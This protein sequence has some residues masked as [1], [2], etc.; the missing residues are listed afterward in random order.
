VVS[1][2]ES[3]FDASAVP[4]I[5]GGPL[6]NADL[7]ARAEAMALSQRI[8]GS[9][10][11]LLLDAVESFYLAK[12]FN[13]TVLAFDGFTNAVAS[14]ALEAVGA[15]LM[16]LAVITIAT[17]NDAGQDGR[18]S[19]LPHTLDRLHR[20]LDGV[21]DRDV[22]TEKAGVQD[23]KASVNADVVESLKYLRHLRNKWAGHA[24]LDRSIDS[25]ADADRAVS[26]PLIEDALVRL[27]NAHQRL[28]DM[29]T[30][31]DVLTQLTSEPTRELSAD[32]PVTVPMDVD[33][34]AVV[35]HALLVR[36]WAGRAAAALVDQLQAPP[37][38]GS[39][40]DTDWRPDSQH[41]RL[42]R[43]IDDAVVRFTTGESPKP[44][45]GM[46]HN[47]ADIHPRPDS[48]DVAIDANEQTATC[49]G[50][51]SPTYAIVL[52]SGDN[53]PNTWRTATL[54]REPRRGHCHVRAGL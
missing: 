17:V 42:R 11:T 40:N 6:P 47:S 34:S 33:W 30:A 31:S 32:R 14:S 49:F 43:S 13:Q 35:P 50:L 27:V 5:D 21:I 8:A 54:E 23:L 24:S 12:R 2:F 44:S 16:R 9:Q 36:D 22:S 37:G 52:A 20:A 46:N 28:A 39:K 26:L 51:R 7:A 4:Q 38:Y 53:V 48:L 45:P 3:E 29:V 15:R 10:Q 18:T 1:R 19:S 25:W 41:D